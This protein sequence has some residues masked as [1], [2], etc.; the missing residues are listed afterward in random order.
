MPQATKNRPRARSTWSGGTSGQLAA[1]ARDLGARVQALTFARTDRLLPQREPASPPRAPSSLSV[2][3]SSSLSA[4]ADRVLAM[5]LRH[6]ME[7]M[8]VALLSRAMAG[9]NGNVTA[10]ARLLGLHRKAVERLL[11]KH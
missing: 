9:A 4:L 7:A 2:G 5:E 3:G 10:A 8:R 1:L 11:A 6:P